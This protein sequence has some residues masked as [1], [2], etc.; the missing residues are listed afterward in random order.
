MSNITEFIKNFAHHSRLYVKS[1]I[2][3]RNI[4]HKIPVPS[5]SLEKYILDHSSPIF[6]LSTGRCGTS[7]LT[8]LLSL[9][10]RHHVEHRGRPELSAISDRMYGLS[11]DESSKDIL[12]ATRYETIRELFLNDLNYI[13][14]NNRITFFAYAI[15]ELFPQSKFIHLYRDINKFVLSGLNRDWYSGTLLYDDGRLIPTKIDMNNSSQAEKIAALYCET[16]NFIRDFM[17][18]CP[19]ARQF[20]ISSRELFI[21]TPKTDSL[22]TFCQQNHGI[23]QRRIQRITSKRRN[24]NSKTRY[25]ELSEEQKRVIKK[26]TELYALDPENVGV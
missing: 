14:T 18:S 2:H 13:E 12:L 3:H 21:D 19:D 20:T 23:N 22:L 16:N 25:K 6:V 7:L 11:Q 15:K 8:S 9:L 10:N 24:A 4:V 26:V 17:S 1:Y 5:N